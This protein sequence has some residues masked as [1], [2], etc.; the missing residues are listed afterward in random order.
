MAPR[1]PGICARRRAHAA[2]AASGWSGAWGDR[3]GHAHRGDDRLWQVTSAV[4]A[5]GG[6]DRLLADEAGRRRHQRALLGLRK[7]RPAQDEVPQP[8]AG[9]WEY[10]QR[11]LADCGGNVSD[12]ARRLRLHRRSLQRKLARHA[13][14]Q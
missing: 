8:R 14:R 12:A 10:L 6:R 3:R 11:V 7:V 13:P 4:A 2:W 1:R 9:Q 5:C